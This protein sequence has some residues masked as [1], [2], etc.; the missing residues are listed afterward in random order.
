MGGLIENTAFDL[1]CQIN[2]S[3]INDKHLL[4]S[5]YAFAGGA[6]F[7]LNP[8]NPGQQLPTPHF[9]IKISDRSVWSFERPLGFLF[10]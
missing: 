5:L 2:D 3:K 4:P 8:T 9:R 7:I 1:S 6:D 10:L